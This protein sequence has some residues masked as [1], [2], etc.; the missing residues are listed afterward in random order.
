MTRA[1]VPLYRPVGAER[2]LMEIDQLLSPEAIVANLRATSKKQVLQELSRTAA[3]LTGK[4]ESQIFEV[5]LERERRGSTGGG[6][7]LEIP[8]GKLPGLDRLHGVFAR[9]VK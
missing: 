3:D 4:D 6:S 8:H 9:L 7:G 5:L 2:G 1:S